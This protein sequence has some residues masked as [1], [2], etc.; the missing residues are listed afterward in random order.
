[1]NGYTPRDPVVLC[2]IVGLLVGTLLTGLALSRMPPRR[3]LRLLAWLLTLGVTLGVE[4][5]SRDEP[6]GLRMLIIIAALLY[7]MKAVVTIEARL[8]GMPAYSPWWW[9]GFA[10]LWPGMRPG[11]FAGVTKHRAGG[12]SLIVRGFWNGCFGFVLA[13]LS[14]VVWQDGRPSLPEMMA[15]LLSTMLL[16]PGLS[17]MLHFG[18]FNIL[19][20]LWRL[21]GVDAQPLFR[22]PLRSRSLGEFWGRRWN[23]AFAE[24]TA[25]S[26][27]RPISG[28]WGRPI[29][30]AAAFLASGLL[31]ELAI[32]VPVFAGF[33][34]PFAYFLLHAALVLVEQRLER[35]G[36]PVSQWGVW[37]H[38]WVLG[39]LTLPVPILFHISFLR[40][41]VWPLI[42]ME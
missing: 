26:V 30:M 11:L 38:V 1:M 18:I 20:G 21:A 25:I 16:L 15:R 14:W 41:V 7:G 40:G 10:A 29:A 12:W 37:S 23:L 27:Y 8:E 33:G 34:L 19:A 2:L 24:M 13:W 42:G 28:P 3:L 9:L 6:A 35:V 5:L 17:L 39:W 22:A 31:H 32:S 4:R 36:N